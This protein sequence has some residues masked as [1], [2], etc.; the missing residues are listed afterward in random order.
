MPVDA[1]AADPLLSD[2]LPS[3]PMAPHQL[4]CRVGPVVTLC[5]NGRHR[6]PATIR[7]NSSTLANECHE[8]RFFAVLADERDLW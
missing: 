4:L 5:L 3:D 1:L 7:T 6:N 8:R 2:P